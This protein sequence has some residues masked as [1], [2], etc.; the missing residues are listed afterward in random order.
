MTVFIWQEALLFVVVYSCTR[1]SFLLR[2]PLPRDDAHARRVCVC[3]KS[4]I[5][6]TIII[7]ASNTPQLLFIHSFCPIPTENTG[8][9]DS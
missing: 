1:L 4:H 9:P 5:A 8:A 2:G 7:K 3:G 6:G